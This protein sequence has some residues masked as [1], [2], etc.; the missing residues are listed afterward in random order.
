MT[1]K[2]GSAYLFVALSCASFISFLASEPCDT[3]CMWNPWSSWSDC[4]RLCAGGIQRRSRSFCC[5]ID[6][7]D[8]SRACMKHCGMDY[9]KEKG[10]YR[11][12]KNCNENCYNGGNFNSSGK[13]QCPDRFRGTCCKD[14][15]TC[16]RPSTVTYGSFSGSD[17][18]YAGTVR[19]T[20]DTNYNMTNPSQSTRTCT[21]NGHW[22]GSAPTCIYA[23]S[24]NSSSCQNGASC[25]N[26]L[27]DYRCDCLSGWTGKN[28]E[29][30]IQPPVV[31]GCPVD[32]NIMTSNLTS[33]QTWSEPKITDPHGT[34][35][36][37]TKNYQ[38]NSFEFP[39]GEFTIQ[40][41]AVKISN[42]LKAECKFTISVTRACIC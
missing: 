40:Y 39:W 17:F 37:V 22:N 41:S 24:C 6:L 15:V 7:A 25:V 21:E 26:L 34:N 36:S 28:C 10:G 8:D 27:G 3:R 4:S 20:C 38:T 9:D 14:V 12:T 32:R 13:C 31:E 29:V 23:T 42:G 35:V 33:R 11:D 2:M 16:G 19:Y 18:T 30:D 1:G 5:R